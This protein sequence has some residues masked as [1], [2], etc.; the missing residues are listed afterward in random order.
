MGRRTQATRGPE[1]SARKKALRGFRVPIWAVVL[2]GVLVLGGAVVMWQGNSG[3][4]EAEPSRSE[5]PAT[6]LPLAQSGPPLRAGHNPERIPSAPPTPAPVPEGAPGPRL[7]L[8]TS[9]HDFGRISRREIVTHIFAVQNVG[10]SDLVIRNLVTSCGCTTAELSSS[11]VPPGHRADLRVTFDADYHEIRGDVVRV[12][13]FA[14][15]DPAHP[16]VEVRITADVG[17]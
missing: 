11:V 15:N 10:T 12:V 3:G 1:R 17:R 7:D 16:W 2:A 5:D 9:S 8:P 13:W 4:R 6:L 14:T